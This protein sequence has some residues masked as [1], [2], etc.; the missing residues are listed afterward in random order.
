MTDSVGV[1]RVD[2]ARFD[3]DQPTEQQRAW[4]AYASEHPAMN[5]YHSLQWRDLLVDVFGL[6]PRLYMARR[7][8]QVTGLLPVYEVRFPLLGSKFVSLPYEA[9]SGGPLS[10][11]EES[12]RALVSA[13]IDDARAAGA[14]HVEVRS[15]APSPVFEQLGFTVES[16]VYH[17]EVDLSDGEA[18]W[19]RVG[20]DQRGKMRKAA[21]SGVTVRQGHSPADYQA[22]YQVYL[23]SF[24]AFGT[25][26]YGTRYYPTVH[27]R[28]DHT[29]QSNLFLAEVEGEA[30]GGYLLFKWGSRAVNKISCVLPEALR[31]GVFPALYGHVFGWCIENDVTWLSYGT[32]AP[33]DQGLVEYKERWAATTHR[34]QR[35]TLALK[36][37]VTPLE[38]YYKPDTLPKRMWKRLPRVATPLL[39]H[40]LNRWFA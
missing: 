33:D 10:E 6:R 22:Y 17:S 3:A 13:M 31:L 30:V 36:G 14:Q 16:S 34:V 12:S 24:H 20:R 4:Q 26:P 9:G 7:G 11:D 27:Q 35:C 40:W 37:R 39:G 25:P 2:S 32:S 23:R 5:L 28:L 15:L 8:G 19:K 1:E 29:G 38:D 18:A 21:R